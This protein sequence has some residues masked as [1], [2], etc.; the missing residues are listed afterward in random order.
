MV[1]SQ[2]TRNLDFA[3]NGGVSGNWISHIMVASQEIGFRMCQII[4][5]L[6]PIFDVMPQKTFG[7]NSAR[8][9]SVLRKNQESL[10]ENK[11]R[12]NSARRK[13]TVTK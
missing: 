4:G 12:T 5:E 7:E 11:I 9:N 8:K 6:I 10:R 1:A 3:Y 13:K 2:E